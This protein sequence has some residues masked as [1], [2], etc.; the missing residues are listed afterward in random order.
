MPLASVFW[1]AGSRNLALYGAALMREAHSLLK[2]P[3]EVAKNS[4]VFR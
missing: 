3:N 4:L 2:G 1:L